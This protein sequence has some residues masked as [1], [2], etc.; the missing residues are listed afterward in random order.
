MYTYL[1][2]SS[3]SSPKTL[4]IDGQNSSR[5]LTSSHHSNAKTM[6][7]RKQGI[8]TILRVPQLYQS[9]HVNST[10]TNRITPNPTTTKNH[11]TIPS[12]PLA[13]QKTSL[14]STHHTSTKAPPHSSSSPFQKPPVLRAYKRPM[15]MDNMLGGNLGG[16]GGGQFPLEQWFYEMP[17][18]TRLWTTATVATSILVQCQIV[19][20]FQ[21]F[22]SY[23]AVFVKNQ[24]RLL[25]LNTLL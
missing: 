20:P 24:V 11:E 19:T 3:Y 18:C 16:G 4:G 25:L 7:I 23:R 22:Y 14:R 6:H 1:L 5:P 9:H 10:L 15:D 8:L 17:I 21:L 13:R 2:R 12:L